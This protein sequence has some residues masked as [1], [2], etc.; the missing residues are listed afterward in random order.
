LAHEYTHI[1]HLDKA[2]GWIG[3]LPQRLRTCARV[4]S[5]SV[6]ALWQIEG[7]ATYNE[8][9]L[10][11]EGRVADRRLPHDRRSRRGGSAVRPDRSANGGLIDWPEDR[12]STRTA[13]TSINNLADRYGPE[14]IAKLVAETSGRLPY[15]GA[16]A[17]R[18]VFKRSLGELWDDFETDTNTRAG[19]SRIAP[20]RVA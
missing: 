9:V 1:V 19:R 8:S 10:T 17:F 14:S 16:P 15:L 11:G 13:H 5:E 2:R 12:R 18:K 20:A 6:S 7:I 4:V 3:G